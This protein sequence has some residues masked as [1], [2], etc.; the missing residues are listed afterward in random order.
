MTSP[1]RSHVLNNYVEKQ[2][3]NNRGS[4]TTINRLRDNYRKKSDCIIGKGSAASLEKI[5]Y[6]KKN[7]AKQS[8]KQPEKKFSTGTPT[9]QEMKMAN[10]S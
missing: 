3:N 6:T 10:A 8:P 4:K 9:L 7:T 2:A 1:C 5:Y